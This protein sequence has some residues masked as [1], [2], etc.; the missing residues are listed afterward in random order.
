LAE[1]DP[2]SS[3]ANDAIDLAWVLELGLKGNEESLEVYL[4]SIKSQYAGDSTLTIELL[5]PFLTGPKT[6]LLRPRAVYRLGSL[7][8]GQGRFDE[9]IA[10]F[11][12]L[13]DDHPDDPL[14]ADANC[15]MARVYEYGFGDRER[16]LKMYEHVLMVYPDYM[17][18]DEVRKNVTR[19]RGEDTL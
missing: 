13:V 4:A 17:F 7:Y 3:F 12:A 19:L 2:S 5:E 10:N 15:R 1:G 16:A 8:A 6:N 18:L 9:A 14:V 11:Q